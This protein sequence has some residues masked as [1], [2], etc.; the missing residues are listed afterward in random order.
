[1]PEHAPSRRLHFENGFDVF[2]FSA[3]KWLIRNPNGM[4]KPSTLPDV[5]GCASLQVVALQGHIFKH[6]VED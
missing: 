2:I 4:R 5:R 6:L 3:P 1:M